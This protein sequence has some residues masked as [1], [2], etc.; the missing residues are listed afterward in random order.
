MKLLVVRCWVSV[1]TNPSVVRRRLSVAGAPHKLGSFWVRSRSTFCVFNNL[2][3]SFLVFNRPF[4]RAFRVRHALCFAEGMLGAVL[5]P[6]DLPESPPAG[7]P[8]PRDEKTSGSPSPT[9]LQDQCPPR[10]IGNSAGIHATYLLIFQAHSGFVRKTLDGV[11]LATCHSPL[12]TVPR[13]GTSE[14]V[15][16]I[17]IFAKSGHFCLQVTGNRQ[18]NINGFV[19]GKNDVSIRIRTT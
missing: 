1:A 4:L 2:V 6:A 3:A 11:C 18:V 15:H 5:S 16:S 14:A 8:V 19:F 7:N 10:Q 12:A 17:H 9:D 13:I